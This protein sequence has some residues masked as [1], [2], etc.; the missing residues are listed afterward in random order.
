MSANVN[1]CSTKSKIKMTPVSVSDKES[2]LCYSTFF[3]E[4]KFFNF[5]GKPNTAGKKTGSVMKLNNTSPTKTKIATCI[6]VTIP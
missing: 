6:N 3:F 2:F 1:P 4:T 5:L